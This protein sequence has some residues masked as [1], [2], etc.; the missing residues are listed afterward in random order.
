MTDTPMAQE[1]VSREVLCSFKT[2]LP[3]P[4]RISEEFSITLSTSSTTKDLTEV[5][6]QMLLEEN[7]LEDEQE[8]I[9]KTRK[10]QFLCQNKILTGSLQNLMEKL[11]KHSESVLVLDYTF[12]LD[13]PKPKASIPQDEWISVLS[14]LC[15]SKNEKPK[16]FVAGFFNGDLKVFDGKNS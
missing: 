11:D 4:F 6:K 14:S 16:T 15:H 13:K 7:V 1:G 10:L 5:L 8:R 12:S 9:L 2:T 3:E